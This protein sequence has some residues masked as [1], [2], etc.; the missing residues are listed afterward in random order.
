MRRMGF[1]PMI[2]AFER[3]KTVHT[4]DRAATVFGLGLR[5]TVKIIHRFI[6][7]LSPVICY[8][9]LDNMKQSCDAHQR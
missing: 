1:E 6:I 8:P 4:L 2:R 5:W 7:Q 9:S 3:E